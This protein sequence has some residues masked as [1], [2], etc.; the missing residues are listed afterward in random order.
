MHYK[1]N[2]T[3]R[4]PSSPVASSSPPLPRRGR[5]PLRRGGC[6]RRRAHDHAHAHH[7]DRGGPL[8]QVGGEKSIVAKLKDPPTIS[9]RPR[10]AREAESDTSHSSADYNGSSSDSDQD[11]SLWKVDSAKLR[12]PPVRWNKNAGLFCQRDAYWIDR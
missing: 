9:K 4:P 1:K 10:I 6:A 11:N 7:G 3:P 5:L 12:T 2:V 8:H